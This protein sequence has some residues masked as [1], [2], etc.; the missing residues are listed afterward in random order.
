M[1]IGS[2]TIDADNFVTDSG[3]RDSAIRRFVLQSGSYPVITFTPTAIEGVP[4]SVA[5]GDTLSLQ[6]T[7]DL[8]IRKITRSETFAI[9]V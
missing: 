8:T 2:I 9:T 7:G 3:R 6:A 1:A 4:A 5:V